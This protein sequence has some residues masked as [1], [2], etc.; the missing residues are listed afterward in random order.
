[1]RDTRTIE[2]TAGDHP[3]APAATDDKPARSAAPPPRDLHPRKHKDLVAP[4]SGSNWGKRRKVAQF[5]F[6][7]KNV[8]ENYPPYQL[9][10][11]P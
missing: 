1:M 7:P 2:A 8:V 6:D 10:G 9:F 5:T 11:V 4:D 3:A